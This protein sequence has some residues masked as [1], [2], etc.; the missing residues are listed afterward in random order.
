MPMSRGCGEEK[1]KIRKAKVTVLQRIL[2]CPHAADP[3][4][5]QEIM[6]EVHKCESQQQGRLVNNRW[7]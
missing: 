5:G 4:D 1:Q 7:A 3:Y 2:A 6:A